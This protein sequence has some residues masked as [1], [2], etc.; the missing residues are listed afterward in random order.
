MEWTTLCRRTNDPKLTAIEV[1]LDEIGVAHHRNGESWHAP[2]LEVLESDGE[3]A[4]AL[5]GKHDRRW[6]NKPLDDVRDDAPCWD[7]IISA[8]EPSIR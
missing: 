4:W 6:G 2:I 1:L 3:K 5:L 8:S 7:R